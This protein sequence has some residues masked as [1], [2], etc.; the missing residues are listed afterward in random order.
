[1]SL[2]FLHQMIRD[3]FHI[4]SVTIA[5]FE[6]H[7]LIPDN[8]DFSTALPLAEMNASISANI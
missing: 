8:G 6:N 7:K 2:T 3:T 1:M 5:D 4:L